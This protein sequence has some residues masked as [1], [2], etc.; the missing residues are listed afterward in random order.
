MSRYLIAA[1]V[2]FLFVLV[3]V[4]GSVNLH[5]TPLNWGVSSADR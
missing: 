5:F 2:A 1:L 4:D 3:L